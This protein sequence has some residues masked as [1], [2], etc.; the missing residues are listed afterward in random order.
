[1]STVAHRRRPSPALLAMLLVL[2]LPALAQAQLFPNLQVKRQRPACATEDPIYRVYRQQFYGYYPTQWRA[3]PPGWHLQNPEGVSPAQLE[4]ARRD[5][6][7]EIQKEAEA[8][9]TSPDE[10]GAEPGA[11][12]ELPSTT[13]PS[14][15]APL[16][17]PPRGGSVFDL[18]TPKPPADPAPLPNDDDTTPS[19]PRASTER[20][21]A[22]PVADTPA[23]PLLD[24]APPL[25]DPEPAPSAATD[26]PP[27]LPPL[28]G[29]ISPGANY[30]PRDD[31]LP[32]PPVAP[33]VTSTAPPRRRT[34]LIGGLFDTLRGKRRR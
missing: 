22:E 5:I 9:G 2:G 31:D 15:E 29:N 16:P 20:P 12:S 33:V 25:D 23:D 30:A 28:D 19:V 24:S 17:L 32:P 7:N 4:A 13:E 34:T 3:F 18:P 6:Q 8:L 26:S 14:P 27:A 10:E 21:S 11:D 1:M